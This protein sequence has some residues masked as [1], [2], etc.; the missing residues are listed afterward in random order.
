MSGFGLLFRLDNSICNSYKFY[1]YCN[2]AKQEG[3]KMEAN[4]ILGI[5]AFFG[6]TLVIGKKQAEKLKNPENK[7]TP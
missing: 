4:I 3:L 7:T 5:I 1:I 2:F 6:I